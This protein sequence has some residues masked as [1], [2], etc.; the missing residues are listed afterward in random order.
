EDARIARR[1]ARI[2]DDLLDLLLAPGHTE[3]RDDGAGPTVA[4]LAAGGDVRHGLTRLRVVDLADA[5]GVGERL[6]AVIAVRLEEQRR[7]DRLARGEVRHVGDRSV[8][9]IAPPEQIQRDAVAP[10]V[11]VDRRRAAH[12]AA[13]AFD[14]VDGRHHA[15]EQN[16]LLVAAVVRLARLRVPVQLPLVRDVPPE[17]EGAG[18]GVIVL[19]R[20]AGAAETLPVADEVHLEGCQTLVVHDLAD[21]GRQERVLPV[22]R[23]AGVETRYRGEAAAVI[24]LVG[25]ALAV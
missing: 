6:A 24:G 10:S 22:D 20:P 9:G 15:I 12:D 21:R 13:V 5:A 17:S 3:S 18:S 2:P 8:G 16:A 11:G 7:V 19:L 4:D 23:D 14:G 1:V 25:H